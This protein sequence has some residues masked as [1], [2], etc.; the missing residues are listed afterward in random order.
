MDLA[1][2]KDIFMNLPGDW[3]VIVMFASLITFDSLWHGSGRATA[4]AISFPIS[5]LLITFLPVAYFIGRVWQQLPPIFFALFNAAIF[6]VSYALIRR[7]SPQYG[8]RAGA[9]IQ[10]VISGF[11]TAIVV[12]IVWLQIPQL[13]LLWNF[14]SQVQ[15]VFGDAYQFW[16]LITGLL[17]LLFVR[18]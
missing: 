15:A 3:L 6:A 2:I 14:G 18:K 17:A 9:I 12:V 16:W 5:Y 10:A 11:A 8:S 13:Q 7:I 4:I 1:V